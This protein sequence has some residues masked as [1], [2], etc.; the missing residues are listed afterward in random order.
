MIKII[1]PQ[2]TW[3][4][5]GGGAFGAPRG[6]RKHMGIDLACWE[7]SSI[8]TP[9]AGKVTKIGFPYNPD[10]PKKGRL[11]YVEILEQDLYRCRYFYVFPSVSPGDIVHP[12][13]IIGTAQGL[14]KIYPGIT[15]HFHYEVKKGGSFVDPNEY[16]RKGVA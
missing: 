4:K 5:F 12:G 13:D 11:R 2:R 15:D 7:G 9:H 6:D 8:T 3:D 16:L 1:P 10:D 14:T